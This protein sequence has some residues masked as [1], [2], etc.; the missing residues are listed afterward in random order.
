MAIVSPVGF[1]GMAKAVLL[2]IDSSWA[3]V[4]FRFAP[5]D[6]GPAT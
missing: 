4:R 1:V 6:L 5:E 2:R 3:C